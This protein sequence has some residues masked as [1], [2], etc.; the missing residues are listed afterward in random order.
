M[1]FDGMFGKMF[2]RKGTGQDSAQASLGTAPLHPAMAAELQRLDHFQRGLG[3]VAQHFV[4]TGEQTGVLD[5]IASLRSAHT[6]Y[7]SPYNSTE[8]RLPE[9]QGATDLALVMGEIAPGQHLLRLLQIRIATGKVGQP[10]K[11]QLLP[12]ELAIKG[13]G[14]MIF[15]GLHRSQDNY[16]TPWDKIIPIKTVFAHYRQIGGTMVDLFALILR[17]AETQYLSE[18]NWSTSADLGAYLTTY[19]AA[20]AQAL[21]DADGKLRLG[22]VKLADHHNATTAPE[23]TGLMVEMLTKPFD[24]DAREVAMSALAR[25]APAQLLAVLHDELPKGDIDTR[26]GLVQAA[27]RAG[28]AEIVNLLAERARVEKAGKVQAAIQAI[29]E[30]DAIAEMPADRHDDVSPTVPTIDGARLTLPPRKDIGT[31]V[32]LP[33]TDQACIDFVALVDRIEQRRR[34]SHEAYIARYSDQRAAQVKPPEP[35]ARDV[36]EATF[37]ALTEAVRLPTGMQY[38]LM[39]SVRF[40]DDGQAW[41]AAVLDRQAIGASL[42]IL[43]CSGFDDVGGVLGTSSIYRQDQRFGV[44]RLQHWLG[45]ARLDLRDIATTEHLRTLM[46]A[47]AHYGSSGRSHIA[48]LQALPQ[49]AVWPW[50]VEN[51]DVLDEAM[52]LKP[53]ARP[54]PL[55]RALDVLALLPCLPQRY[56]AKLLD[57]AVA[58]KRPL[59]KKAMALVRDAIDL[60]AR[61]ETLLADKRQPVRINAAIWLADIRSTASIGIMRKRL[62]KEKSDPVRAALIESLQRLGADLGDVIGPASLIA[63]ADAARAKHG[64]PELPE[65]IAPHGLPAPHFAD[66]T[67]VPAQVVRH[68]LALAIRLKDPGACGQFGIYLDQLLPEDAR[69]FSNWVLDSWISYD[70]HSSSLEDATAYAQAN[71]QASWNWV[72]NP[73]KTP[74]LRDQVIAQMIREKTGEL[75]NSGSDTKGILAMACRADPVFAANRVRW[76]LKKHGRRSNQAMALLEVLAGIGQPAALQVVIAASV[77]LKQKSTQARAAEIA[78]RHAEDRGWTMDELADRTV[79]GA[80]F[81]DDGTLELPCGEDAKPYVARLDAMLAIHVFN[82]DGKEVKALPAGDDENTRE[83]KKALTAAKKELA[84]VIELQGTRLFEA[85]CVERKWDVADW[86]MAF[87]DHPVM[88]RLVERLVW[89][90]MDADG[91]ATGLFRPTQEGD[92]TNAQDE[93]VDLS[94]FAQ[95][96]LAHGSL[97][98]E[99]ACTAWS[100]HL[101]DYEIKPFMAQFDTVRAPLSADQANAEAIEDRTGWKAD[102]LT[103]RGVAEKRGYQRVMRDGGG[104]NEYEKKFPGQGITAT[105]FHTGSYAVDENNPVALKELRFAKAGHRGKYLLKDVPPVMLAECWAD[106][107]AVA[108]KGQFDPEWEKIAPW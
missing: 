80:G 84:Q 17:R 24:K 85:M 67:T 63:E 88:R 74:E 106:Y 27:G 4:A 20:F 60:V 8:P 71:Y 87:H 45:E 107:H 21:R 46:T 86:R 73:L 42:R 9:I 91:A 83:S 79:P 65:W 54:I 5:I 50:L 10:Y 37:A 69:S 49:D 82:P 35:Y 61:I 41:L 6:T 77:R 70:T 66:G 90:G 97:L 53:A 52:G 103:F 62:A 3:R 101:K 36:V 64:E 56:Y 23:F 1:D 33:P 25:L 108:A 81:D 51:M 92:F 29:V 16:R 40:H 98:D 105:I 31:D 14:E 34:D 57:I 18:G 55:D 26:F 68:W 104:C 44:D 75:L 95:V 32:P 72:Y 48:A 94:A 28:G 96:R 89:Q 19:P 13:L 39:H 102:S 11:G 43:K 78:T 30:T 7:Q 12:A 100:A 93:A 2:G 58:E 99:A 38:Q 59:R 76:Y 15:G 47:A 22:G